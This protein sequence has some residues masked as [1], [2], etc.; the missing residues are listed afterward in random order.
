MRA[1]IL[2]PSDLVDGHRSLSAEVCIVGAGAAGIYLAIQLSRRGICV[3]LVEAGSVRP[4][5]SQSIGFEAEFSGEIYGGAV[6]GRYF[7]LGGTTVQWGGQLFPYFP[8]HARPF[9]ASWSTTW[10]T[11]ETTVARHLRSVLAFLDLPD[12]CFSADLSWVGLSGCEKEMRQEGLSITSS[13]WLPFRRRNFVRLLNE[14]SSPSLTVLTDAVAAGW[15]VADLAGGFARVRTL[16]VHCAGRTLEV[17]APYFVITAG[18]IESARLL[19]EL[20]AIHDFRVLPRSAA[21]GCYLSDHLSIAIGSVQPV[22]MKQFVL[23]FAPRFF[24]YGMRSARILGIGSEY[25]AWPRFFAH[26]IFDQKSAGFSVARDFFQSVQRGRLT[27]P[28]VGFLVKSLPGLAQLGWTRFVRK[29]LAIQGQTLV[30]LQLDFEQN[31]VRTNRVTLGREKDRHRRPR[32][33]VHWRIGEQ[34]RKDASAVAERVLSAWKRM[35][36][37]HIVP[38]VIPYA[39][40]QEEK[41]HD[42]YHPVGTTLLG[43]HPEAVVDSDCLVRGT[44]NLWTVSTGIFPTAGVANPT[45]SL[46][47]FADR[48]AQSLIG[49]LD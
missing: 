31:P 5:D 29:R 16:A 28:P 21:C 36:E 1:R 19:L 41:L 35:G 38:P 10:P 32:A 22:D 30:R 11:I 48:L 24:R 44:S 25:A 40:F 4:Q 15:Q 23:L 2:H 39:S 8:T 6:R 45:L 47:C 46:L 14:E 42:V 33:V 3:L 26:W 13:I 27:A 37:N 20:D 49:K 17:T 43:D 34:D 12:E 7:G 9:D 18:A